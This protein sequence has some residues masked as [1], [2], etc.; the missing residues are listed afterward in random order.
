[1]DMWRRLVAA[2]SALALFFLT[3]Q[4]ASAECR[5]PERWSQAGATPH[6]HSVNAKPGVAHAAHHADEG[7]APASD[8]APNASHPCTL[9]SSC[10]VTLSTVAATHSLGV[11]DKGVQRAEMTPRILTSVVIA[12]ELPPPRA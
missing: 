1:M 12:P 7:K 10:V 3:T 9:L 11:P 6:A 4:A 2:L 8:R 5:M